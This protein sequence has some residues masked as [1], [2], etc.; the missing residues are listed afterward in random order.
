VTTQAPARGSLAEI[1]YHQM[2]RYHSLAQGDLSRARRFRGHQVLMAPNVAN[3][4]RNWRL[5]LYW[6]RVLR[7]L[8]AGD[9]ARAT[10]LLS[11]AAIPGYPVP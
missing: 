1:P 6:R 11:Q 10:Q 3:A 5:F 7:A 2:L 4:R 8:E 9:L